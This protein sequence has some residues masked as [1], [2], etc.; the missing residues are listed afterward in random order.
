MAQ[1]IT[2]GLTAN[3]IYDLLNKQSEELINEWT[4]ETA[5]ETGNFDSMSFPLIKS[6]MP[7]L[8]GTNLISVQPMVDLRELEKRRRHELLKKR[9]SKLKEE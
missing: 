3:N 7:Q 9:C 5:K 1:D 4:D 2:T 8:L 6:I